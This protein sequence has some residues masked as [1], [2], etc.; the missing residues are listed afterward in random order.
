M[1]AADR[2]SLDKLANGYIIGPLVHPPIDLYH[3]SPTDIVQKNI[4]PKN[5]WLYTYLPLIIA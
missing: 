1:E 4:V 5:G 3:I 2:F